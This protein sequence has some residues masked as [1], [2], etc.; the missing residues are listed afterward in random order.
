MKKSI[1]LLVGIALGLVLLRFFPIFLGKTI[2]LGDNI[3]LM[4]PGKLFS[5]QWLRQGIIPFWNPN[6]F[7]GISWIG[8]NNQSMFYPTTVLFMFMHPS[9]ALNLN[10]VVHQVLAF[11]GAAF[12]ARKFV[13]SAGLQVAA[14]V[15]WTFNPLVTA[16]LNNISI[17]QTMA[18]T[19]WVVVAALYSPFW[20]IAACFLQMAAGYPQHVLY[21]IVT[22]VLLQ[23]WVAFQ[24]RDFHWWKW[25]RNWLV[26]GAVTIAVTAVFW[27]PLV[28]DLQN[29]TRSIQ[30]AQQ[31]SS[32]SLTLSDG[33]KFV[34]PTVFDNGLVGMKWGPSW[35]KPPITVFYVPMI[36]L[37][38][39][40]FLLWQ[41]K[42]QKQDW[43]F[44][45]VIGSP[46]LFALLVNIPQFN[47]LYSLPIL[48]MARGITTLLMISAILWSVW[49]VTILE[50]VQMF[51]SKKVLI[52]V[53]IVLVFAGLGY[54]LAG[55]GEGF[56]TVWRQFDGLLGGKLSN[57]PF[58]TIARDQIIAENLFFFV[59]V[60]FGI[61]LAS[62]WLLQK[63]RLLLFGVLLGLE[64]IIISSGHY[65]FAPNDVYALPDKSQTVAPM[66]ADLDLQQYRVLPRNYN[67]PYTDFGMYY[68]ALVT[69]APFSDSF[70]DEHELREFT[71]LKRMKHG[72]TPNWSAQLGIPVITGYTTMVPKSI[73]ESF[74]HTD[75]P[76]LND[77]PEISPL[78][79]MLEQWSVK[80]YLVDT[81]FDIR[82]DPV[83]EMQEEALRELGVWRLYELPALPR[84]RYPD[85]TGV[86]MGDFK[87][88]PNETA[89]RA[90]NDTQNTEMIIADR[91][92]KN[93]KAEVNG[94]LV[95]VQNF[96]GMRKIALPSGYNEVRLWLYPEKFYLGLK[97]SGLTL[98]AIL[99]WLG[100]STWL[101]K[102]PVS[103]S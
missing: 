8:D 56:T 15:L 36:T 99:S 6:F 63:K 34:F 35:S 4:I 40:G 39:M 94:E 89:F 29:S 103:K 10:L 16:S 101:Q 67:A 88:N 85:G 49:A 21:S 86:L 26:I 75:I 1:T 72:A 48:S 62:W 11:V 64:S 58:H 98:V 79:P 12:L 50:R 27:I 71:A 2:I 76:G 33:I 70:I 61:L 91:W 82:K 31:A 52:A 90:I 54:L 55:Y 53:V 73:D 14:G 37:V 23:W 83:F 7:A 78:D 5:A 41:K 59:F 69:R 92:D 66:F 51:L 102:K 77:L 24:K 46:V 84:F 32:G 19:P 60:Q 80:Y 22:A 42:W 65:M 17:S 68:D 87:E 44:S 13:K 47:V 18:W 3:S 38:A 97:I 25:L 20:F 74:N 43:F 30:T 28:E 81:A 95:E 93:W 100:W 96:N 57:S 9:V 45:I